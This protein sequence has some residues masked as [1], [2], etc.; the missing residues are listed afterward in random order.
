MPNAAKHQ[1]QQGID[2]NRIRHR[3]ERDG[4]GAEGERRNRD[5]GIGGID[6]AAD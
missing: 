2:D 4:A 3:E 6:I 1:E 5:K